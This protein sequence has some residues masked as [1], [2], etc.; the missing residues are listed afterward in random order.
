MVGKHAQVRVEVPPL[1]KD[2]GAPVLGDDGVVDGEHVFQVGV[3]LFCWVWVWLGAW[4]GGVIFIFWW[5]RRG[6]GGLLVDT[7]RG[8]SLY[9]WGKCLYAP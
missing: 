3:G 5:C 9:F 6:E 2:G 8:A 4:G 1:P 7:G